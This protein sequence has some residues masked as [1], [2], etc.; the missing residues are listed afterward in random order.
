M[1]LRGRTTPSESER[2]DPARRALPRPPVWSVLV[3]SAT[4]VAGG[5]AF[6]VHESRPP[7]GLSAIRP[8]GIPA[9][10]PTALAS[11]MGLSPDRTRQA[12]DFTLVDQHGQSV[13]LSGLRGRPV[14]L[15]FMD[16]HCTD[17]CPII[18]QEFTRAYAELKDTRPDVAFVAVNVNQYHN[19][20]ADM[21]A[22]TN[23]HGLSSIP[24]WHFV[25][26]PVPTLRRV[27]RDYGIYVDAP[28][29]DA[30]VVHSSVVFFLDSSGRER[31]SASPIDYHTASGDAYLPAGQINQWGH[32]I[33]LVVRSLA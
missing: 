18:S 2:T 12:P 25:T 23:E 24:G 3:A 33:S 5:V 16:P 21:L 7:S 4:L 20:T 6:G 1:T 29:P 8:S 14:V 9:D 31:F 19:T 28:S 15:E 11:L 30:D 27:W 32:G 26:G 13:S 17:I 10:V 22:Y